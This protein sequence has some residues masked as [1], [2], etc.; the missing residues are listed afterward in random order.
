ME[1]NRKRK[2]E[3]WIYNF[4]LLIFWG[5]PKHSHKSV[6]KISFDRYLTSDVSR[7]FFETNAKFFPIF[8]I[9]DELW[10]PWLW[11]MS[12]KITIIHLFSVEI[13]ESHDFFFIS[14]HFVCD[15]FENTSF[16]VL[17]SL[18]SEIKGLDLA[19][20]YAQYLA[21]ASR[22][23]FYSTMLLSLHNPWTRIFLQTI[24][25]TMALEFT[26][27]QWW[28][29]FLSFCVQCFGFISWWIFTMD[30][31]DFDIIWVSEWY[32]PFIIERCLRMNTVAKW[33]TAT[34]RREALT[35]SK[36]ATQIYILNNCCHFTW[37][38]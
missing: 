32:V 4:W 20:R 28:F 8:V 3:R 27:Q 37:F 9:H 14:V 33:L 1:E 34:S 35:T 30:K 16:F 22:F 21:L 13:M 7:F 17:T 24:V 5:N 10:V 25:W 38:R 11:H 36:K 6:K 18:S 26:I 2:E 29:F 19:Q 12:P 31:I 23:F 15:D